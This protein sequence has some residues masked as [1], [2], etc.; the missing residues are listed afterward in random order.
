MNP[1][2]PEYPK[3]YH[4]NNKNISSDKKKEKHSVTGW[5]GFIKHVCQ[6]SMSSLE[7]TAWTWDVEKIWGDMLEPACIDYRNR[8]DFL[9]FGY[10]Y[11]IVPNSTCR[12]CPS[13]V[14]RVFVERL[15]VVVVARRPYCTS[16]VCRTTF[17]S[18]G[19]ASASDDE[20]QSPS[21]T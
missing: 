15:I 17:C 10:R 4:N 9:F 20:P 5:Q 14:I 2:R 3:K 11:S 13:L 6:F 7:K 21:E 18:G 16:S 1:P 12:R 19:C 8:I